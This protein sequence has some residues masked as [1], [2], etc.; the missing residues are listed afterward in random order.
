MPAPPVAY[1][2][3]V[4]TGMVVLGIIFTMVACLDA[5]GNGVPSIVDGCNV[6]TANASGG[7][8]EDKPYPP[9]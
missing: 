4:V 7:E 8:D 2:D 9:P 3:A 6:A 5:G 1:D